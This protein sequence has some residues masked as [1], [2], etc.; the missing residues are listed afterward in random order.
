MF[1]WILF[2]VPLFAR[3]HKTCTLSLLRSSCLNV[4]QLFC[5]LAWIWVFLTDFF[6]SWCR[7]KPVGVNQHAHRN[8]PSTEIYF[9]VVFLTNEVVAYPRSA[10]WFPWLWCCSCNQRWEMRTW[11]FCT[12]CARWCQTRSYKFKANWAAHQ[13][14]KRWVI[15]FL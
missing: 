15:I 13:A 11:F 3:Q 5:F 4:A 1:S 10:M 14:R 8:A 7:A 6:T 12:L 2:P 9:T